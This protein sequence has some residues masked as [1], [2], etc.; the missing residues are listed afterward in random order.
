MSILDA[1][2]GWDYLGLQEGD[3]IADPKSNVANQISLLKE[4]NPPRNAEYEYLREV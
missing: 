4:A 3:P 1:V 2:P